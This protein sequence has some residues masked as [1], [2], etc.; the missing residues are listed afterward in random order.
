VPGDEGAGI[1][2]TLEAKSAGTTSR[3]MTS[4]ESLV[5]MNFSLSDGGRFYC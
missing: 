4:S 3:Q 5:R 2:G 1:D